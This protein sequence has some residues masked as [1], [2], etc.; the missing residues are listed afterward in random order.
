[1]ND[2]VKAPAWVW[3]L[4]GGGFV[5]IWGI[6]LG[7]LEWRASVHASKALAAAGIVPKP[8]IEAMKD[9]IEENEEDIDD[10]TDRW[11]RL[12]DAIAEPD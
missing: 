1:M 5:V 12:V 2:T 4:L 3:W 6:T 10:L 11:N 9:D 8:T 7:F